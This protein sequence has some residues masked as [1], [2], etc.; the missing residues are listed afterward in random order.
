MNIYKVKQDVS[1]RET[2]AQSQ[3]K[4]SPMA[5]HHNKKGTYLLKFRKISRER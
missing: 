5:C 2:Y 4:R 3:P 1:I